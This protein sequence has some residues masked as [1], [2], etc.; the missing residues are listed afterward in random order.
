MTLMLFT[1]T[2]VTSMSVIPIIVIIF[3]ILFCILFSYHLK[4]IFIISI[5]LKWLF[6]SCNTFI[7]SYILSLRNPTK[8]KLFCF[9]L[10]RININVIHFFAINICFYILTYFFLLS[11]FFGQ[12]NRYWYISFSIWLL[13][14]YIGFSFCLFK[15]LS[16]ST[17]HLHIYHY[18]WTSPPR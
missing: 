4:C 14:K 11:F 7:L 6:L 17:L 16:L 18:S 2:T 3:L 12:I 9:H 5:L 15:K 10:D 13:Y 1:P 8:W